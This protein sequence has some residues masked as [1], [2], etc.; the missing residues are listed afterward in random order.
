MSR[1]VKRC[2]HAISFAADEAGTACEQNFT[3]KWEP[4]E[5][6]WE[7]PAL[8][9][10]E[11]PALLVWEG[12]KVLRWKRHSCRFVHPTA[13]LFKRQECRFYGDK[14]CYNDCAKY[15]M[16]FFRPASS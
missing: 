6:V 7:G 5:L 2:A 12:S 10:W 9:V 3:H 8:L 11:G 4:A 15:L 1:R 14:R 16:V 13:R